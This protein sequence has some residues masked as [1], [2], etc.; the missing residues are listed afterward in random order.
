MYLA[1][2]L[3]IST[4]IARHSNTEKSEV[5]LDTGYLIGVP[6]IIWENMSGLVGEN[7]VENRVLKAKTRI[8]W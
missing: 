2:L 4:I 3:L 1:L 5:K 8:L 6:D 7:V